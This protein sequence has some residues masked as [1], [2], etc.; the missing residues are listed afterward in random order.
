[1]D[2]A[3]DS[4]QDRIGRRSRAHIRRNSKARVKKTELKPHLKSQW[5]IKKGEDSAFVAAMEDILD[6]YCLP[7]DPDCPVICMDEKPYQLVG[8]IVEPLPMSPGKTRKVDS[9]YKRNGTC[10]IF[11]YAEAA[12]HSETGRIIEN[13][14]LTDD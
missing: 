11:V 14:F 6:T 9:E 12:S 4:G 10:A 2:D 5:C 8:N 7:Y 1:M 13:P 3:N